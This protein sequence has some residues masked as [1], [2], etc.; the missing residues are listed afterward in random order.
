MSAMNI[1]LERAE[2]YQCALINDCIMQKGEVASPFNCEKFGTL[3][4]EIRHG[5]MW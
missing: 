5:L 3:S 4:E 2:C 1:V